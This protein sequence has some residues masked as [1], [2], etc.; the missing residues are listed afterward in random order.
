MIGLWSKFKG[1]ISALG[2]GLA[3]VAGAFFVGR[4]EGKSDA[5]ADEAKALAEARNKARAVEDDVRK[6]SDT[7]IDDRLAQWMRDKR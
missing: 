6:S 3:I 5:K 4:R 1:W 2:F 7:D